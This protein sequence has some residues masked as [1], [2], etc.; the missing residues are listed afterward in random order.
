MPA[1]ILAA[2][3][4]VPQSVAPVS[5]AEAAPVYEN[6]TG[7][8]VSDGTGAVIPDGEVLTQMTAAED[9]TVNLTFT[10]TGSGV[11]SLFFMG[12]NTKAN[13]YITVYISGNKLGVESRSDEVSDTYQINDREYTLPEGT[14]LSEQHTLSFVLD[15]GASYSF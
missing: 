10:A 4:L 12:D 15:G 9:A 13:T 2:A 5:A 3:M 1:A 14:D 7:A 6:E 8:A 11:Q